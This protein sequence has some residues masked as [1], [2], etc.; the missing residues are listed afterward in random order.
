[1]VFGN[2]NVVIKDGRTLKIENGIEVQG[3]GSLTLKTTPVCYK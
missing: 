2:K 1:L 3:T